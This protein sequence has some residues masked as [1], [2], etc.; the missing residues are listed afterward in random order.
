MHIVRSCEAVLL[1]EVSAAL[2]A[3][4]ETLTA[5]Q[6][7]LTQQLAERDAAVRQLAVARFLL[8]DLTAGPDRQQVGNL[9]AQ[10]NHQ[11]LPRL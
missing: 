3:D 11:R 6:E 2:Q 1:Q 7:A 4:V 8:A 9:K 10:R 5:E